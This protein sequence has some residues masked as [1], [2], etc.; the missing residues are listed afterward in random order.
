MIVLV[1]GSSPHA[2]G[3]PKCAP[4]NRCAARFIP[5][6]A[7]NA[8]YIAKQRKEAAVHPRMRGERSLAATMPAP[9]FGSS[10]HARGTLFHH[11][12]QCRQPRFIPACAGNAAI[13]PLVPTTPPVH[14]RMRGERVS[15]YTRPA[16]FT[17]SSPHARGTHATS[18]YARVWVRFIPACAGNAS[19]QKCL[20]CSNAVHPRM[21]GE[22]SISSYLTIDKYGSSPHARGTR[23][24]SSHFHGNS[25]F[26]PACAG[27][28]LPISY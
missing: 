5:A 19:L 25:R 27:N 13:R 20:I 7:G 22:R 18:A 17:G 10:P 9:I 23:K 26:I 21:R 4:D 8:W 14:P 15:P 2:R 24:P 6:C 1:D 16:I 28:A 11:R 3:T 12:T